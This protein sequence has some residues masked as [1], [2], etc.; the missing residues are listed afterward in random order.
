MSLFPTLTEA[1][2][3]ITESLY[4]FENVGAFIVKKGSET[5]YCPVY[6]LLTK[7]QGVDS[8]KFE[9]VLELNKEKDIVAVFAT[10]R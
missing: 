10:I 2:N 4:H 6:V 5:L 1:V 8:Y 3:E 9:D 7:S